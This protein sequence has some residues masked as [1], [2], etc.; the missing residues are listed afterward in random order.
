MNEIKLDFKPLIRKLEILTKKV[1]ESEYSGEFRSMQKKKGIEFEDFQRFSV[2]QDA[3]LI[4]WKASLKHRELLMRQYTQLKTLNM[5]IVM[6]VSNSMLFSSTPKIKCEYAAELAASLSY[7]FLKNDDIVSLL[8]FNDDV[9]KFIP[10]SFGA[11][12]FSLISRALTEPKLYGGMHGLTKPM[13]FLQRFARPGSVIIIIS[14]FLGLEQRWE[15][16]LHA[17][18]EKTDVVALIVRDPQDL[19]LKDKVGQTV[20]EDPFSSNILFVDVDRIKKEYASAAAEQLAQTQQLLKKARIESL[21][22][23]TNQNFADSVV[24]FF[25]RRRS[26]WL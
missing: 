12:H 2:G 26:R 9:V 13:L 21:L 17:L 22:L 16:I 7:I 1:V 25:A 15:R 11:R 20:I 5:F 4:D 10:P 23:E 3:S 14:D 8:M 6:D 18:S 19:R 24:R